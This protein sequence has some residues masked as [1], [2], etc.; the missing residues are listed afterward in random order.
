MIIAED[1]IESTIFDDEIENNDDNLD[2]LYDSLIIENNLNDDFTLDDSIGTGDPNGIVLNYAGDEKIDGLPTRRDIVNKYSQI[3]NAKVSELLLA[4]DDIY[5]MPNDIMESMDYYDRRR[6]KLEIYGVLIDGSKAKVV[7]EGID[8]FFDIRSTSLSDAKLNQFSDSY[9]YAAQRDIIEKMEAVYYY[10]I[11]GY[12]KEPVKYIRVYTNSIKSRRE[13]IAIARAEGLETA[14]DDRSCYYRKAA[15]EYGFTLSDWSILSKYHYDDDPKMHTFTLNVN[16]YKPLIK[17]MASKEERNAASAIKN[18]NPYLIKDRTLVFAWDIETYSGRNVGEVPTASYDEDVCF[19]ICISMHWKDDPTPLQQICIVDVDTMPDKRWTTI[20]CNS[21]KNILKAFALCWESFMP[22]VVIGFNDSNYDWP[23]IIEKACLYGILDWMWNKMACGIKTVKESKF[24]PKVR[25]F[26]YLRKRKNKF[27]PDERLNVDGILDWNYQDRKIKISA[28]E[29]F[30]SKFLKVPGS[31]PIDVR[32]CFK[33][34]YPK[35]DT[36]KSGSLK[37]YLEVSGLS[38]KADMPIKRMW[39]YYEK[40]KHIR[41]LTDE[42]HITREHMRHVAHYCIIDAAR[43]QELFIRRNVIN[44]YREVGSLAFVS[45]FDSHYYAGGMKV[46]NLLGAYAWNRKI[47][48]SMI[49]NEREETGKYPGAY[50]FPP[51]KG[52]VPNPEKLAYIEEQIKAVK[53]INCDIRADIINRHSIHDEVNKLIRAFDAF[54]ADRPVTGLDFSSLYPSLIM[55]YNLSPEKILLKMEEVEYWRAQ[56]KTIHEIEF[57][58][59]G[60]T[61]RGWSI[62]HNNS[63]D[64]IGLYPSVLIDLFNRRAE[65][66]VILGTHGAIKEMIDLITSCAAK[67]NIS[68]DDATALIYKNA[69]D[70]YERTLAALSPDAPSIKISPGS[71]LAEELADLKRINRNANDIVTGIEKLY[72]EVERTKDSLNIVIQKKYE[73][74]CFDWN[75]A[76]TK[77]NALKVYMNTFYGEAGN[78]LSPFF[79]LQLAGG[80][81]SAGQYNI[82]LVADFVKS[83]GFRIKYGDTDS[84]YLVAPSKYFV[85]C[86]ADYAAN[87]ITREDWYSAMVRITM[88]ALN[89]I[90]DEV[91]AHLKQDNGSPYLKMAYEEVLF[92]VV[93]TGKKKYYGIPHLNEVNFRPKNLFIRGIDVVKQGQPPLAKAIGKRIMWK[94]VEIGNIKNIIQIVE[95]VLR[96]AVINGAQWNFNDFVKSDAWKPNKDNKSVQRFITRMRARHAVEVEENA[97]LVSIG[98]PPK[99]YLYEIPE[100]GERFSY[101]IAKTA[102]AFDMRGRRTV[103]KKGD[104]MEFASAAEKLNIEIDVAFYMISYVVGLCARFINGESKFYSEEHKDDE[105][106]LDELSQK[107]AKKYLENFINGLNNVD[108]ETLKKR[109]YAYRKVFKQVEPIARHELINCIG[110]RAADILH[111]NV[112]NF[113]LFNDEDEISDIAKQIWTLANEEAKVIVSRDNMQC[114]IKYFQLNGINPDGSDCD[115]ENTSVNLYKLVIHPLRALKFMEINFNKELFAMI[116]ALIEIS[117][118]YEADLLR[119]VQCARENGVDESP[120]LMGIK[121]AD[122]QILES[123]RKLWF[124]MIGQ[125]VV[126]MR[127][128]EYIKHLESLKNSRLKNNSISKDEITKNI[129]DAVENYKIIGNL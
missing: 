19:M 123:F 9:I 75:C 111:G 90:R 49:P 112:L 22:D 129:S 71:T 33:K 61:V 3:P 101:I 108:S 127:R 53:S 93:F 18:S 64:E 70:E 21:P 95:D 10:S 52:A 8:V 45:L 119:I 87:I 115:N 110:Q 99:P 120:K 36:P 59:N 126:N 63:Q 79:L 47:L 81:T 54:D 94:S 76:N 17:M 27:N 85:E 88:R 28:E 37:F 62:M 29:I 117:A 78:S 13:A 89:A 16:N 35:S 40:A 83:R 31:V 98:A 103:I 128:M 42:P 114:C 26:N 1:W 68:I 122:A 67:E 23:F 46:C 116:P 100:P 105:K 11:R 102:T 20:V 7:I 24:E 86:D 124:N 6:Y 14:S 74:A 77:Q 72:A 39:N 30:Y 41:G 91:N 104:R 38:G 48:V 56:G 44:D 12:S 43:C 65:L 57:P 92:P 66:K 73:Q 58:F 34:L 32:V 60:R 69:R 84:L 109:G 113:E 2:Y 50:V 80:V 97:H 25:W 106:K 5:F 82:K 51:E 118:R 121:V 4:R 125:H 15:R 96:D 55:T 107:A